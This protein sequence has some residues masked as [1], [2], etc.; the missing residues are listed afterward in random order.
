VIPAQAPDAAAGVATHSPLPH[1]RVVT[2][3]A[4]RTLPA[5]SP[6]GSRT[7][8]ATSTTTSGAHGSPTQRRQAHGSPTQRRQTHTHSDRVTLASSWQPSANTECQRAIP[9]S[10]VA[11]ASAHEPPLRAPLPTLHGRP[12]STWPRLP[13]RRQRTAAAQPGCRTPPPQ[14]MPR[15]QGRSS[16]RDTRSSRAAQT[17]KINSRRGGTRPRHCCLNDAEAAMVNSRTRL[18]H[19]GQ[20]G[21]GRRRATL[22][23]RVSAGPH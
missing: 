10:W 1:T 14:S 11:I 16:A 22:A 12:L 9:S 15:P 7:V 13:P 4:E 19:H 3:G 5:N 8:N 17:H 2:Y 23:G 21:R 18:A 6:S 20:P